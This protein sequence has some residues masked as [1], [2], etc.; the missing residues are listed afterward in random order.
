L[1]AR[2]EVAAAARRADLS[3]RSPYRS[4]WR[5]VTIRREVVRDRRRRHRRSGRRSTRRSCTSTAPFLVHPEVTPS[6][7]VIDRSAVGVMTVLLSVAAVVPR[8]I[9]HPTGAAI[10]AVLVIVPEP[11]AVAFTVNVAVPPLSSVDRRRDDCPCRSPGTLEPA[12]A[13]HV[14]VAARE[15]FAGKLSVTVAAVA[16]ARPRVRR[17][18]RVRHRAVLD[19]REVTPSALL[20]FD[21]SAVGVMT[22]LLS[23]AVLFA[24]VGSV[25]P[26]GTVDRSPCW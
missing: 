3:P 24:G 25:V 22:V 7:L 11:D 18:D 17:D 12:L 16:V 26:T 1:T 6:A 23:V 13:V 2:R 19:S 21:R 20:K 10:V 8:R 14:Q 9:V 15:R 4:T 5:A